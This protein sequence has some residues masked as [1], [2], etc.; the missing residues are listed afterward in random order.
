MKN[1]FE[2]AHGPG[3]E[4]FPGFRTVKDQRAARS[5]AKCVQFAERYGSM[6]DATTLAL[7]ASVPVG[8]EP[9][10]WKAAYGALSAY[11]QK[12]AKLT[13]TRWKD[14]MS[15]ENTTPENSNTPS[16]PSEGVYCGTWVSVDYD[17]RVRSTGGGHAF[18]K[19]V[20][21]ADDGT[22][23]LVTC[24]YESS[25]GRATLRGHLRAAGVEVPDDFVTL[26]VRDV[27]VGRRSRIRCHRL[28]TP[29]RVG[30]PFTYL[31]VDLDEEA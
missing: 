8:P 5:L 28:R 16:S 22:D 7:L 24:S 17:Y 20:F 27:L 4:L 1:K 3:P 29:P 2:P 11:A 10:A 25:P 9:V 12:D 26:D 30:S 19:M 15:T 13:L 23:H 18:L 6:M 21:R 31:P 14:R